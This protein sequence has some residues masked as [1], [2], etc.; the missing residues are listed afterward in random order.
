MLRVYKGV[1][2]KVHASAYIDA[3]A[4]IIGDVEVGEESSIWMNAV[5]RGDVHYIRIGRRSNIQDGTIVHVMNGTHPTSIADDVTIGH[6]AVVHGCTLRSRILV[7]MGAILLN[8]VDVGEDSIVAAGT[9]L[10]E[11]TRIPPR[12]LVMGSPGKVRRALSD[13]EVSSILQY[14]KRYVSYRLDYM[15]QP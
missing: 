9:L 13:A 11:E 1:H 15:N 7:G 10:T 8:G 6:G 5:V 2:P 4:Q 14:S 3:S 12:S